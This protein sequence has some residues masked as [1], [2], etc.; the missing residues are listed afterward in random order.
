MS[1]LQS[2]AFKDLSFVDRVIAWGSER[3]GIDA[4]SWLSWSTYLVTFWVSL[5][6]NPQAGL[7][8][9]TLQGP[10]V[11]LITAV[12]VF[13]LAVMLLQRHMRLALTASSFGAPKKLTTSG[14]FR[15]SRNPIYV[16]FF[17]PLWSL[18]LLSPVAAIV[19]T[20]LYIKVMTRFV[21]R[22]EEA[23]LAATFGADYEAY[24]KAVP[25]WFAGV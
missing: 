24:K 22:R 11:V 19:G 25:R 1:A 4:S 5:F 23:D 16:A 14:V 18:A 15:V 13:F 17:I 9:K 3:T 10:T 8:L 20:V 2:C 21:I 6:L 7:A 12:A